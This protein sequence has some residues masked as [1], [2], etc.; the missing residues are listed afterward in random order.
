MGLTANF[1]SRAAHPEFGELP[2]ILTVGAMSEQDSTVADV[3]TKHVAWQ[4]ITDLCKKAA[5][6][7]TNTA[8]MIQTDEFSLSDSMSA[9]EVGFSFCYSQFSLSLLLIV[10]MV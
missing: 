5:A 4:D 2:T 6:E 1:N 9:V 10:S 3:E 8:P 7:M